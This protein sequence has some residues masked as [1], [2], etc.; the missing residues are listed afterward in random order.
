M[1]DVN[2]R[3]PNWSTNEASNSP[4]GTTTIGTGLDDNLRQIQATIRADLASKGNDIASAGTTD[5]G[6]VAGSFHDITGTTTITGLGSVSAGIHKWLQFD[7]TV[8][9]KYN[10]SSLILP[11][12]AD[13]TAQPGD[14]LYAVSLG[15]GNWIVPAYVPR[16]G[17]GVVAPDLSAFTAE[18]SPATDDT[19]PFSDTSA[20][21]AN[22]KITVS[23][24]L[25]VINSLTE[26]TSPDT[27]ADFLLTYDTSTSSVKKAKPS[28]IAAIAATQAQMETSSL[29]AT[30]YV[31]PARQHLHPGHPK[32][33]VAFDPGATITGSFNVA[34]VTKHGTGDYTVTINQTLSSAAFGATVTAERTAG[35][36]ILGQVAAGGKTTTTCRVQ[37]FGINSAALVDPTSC[38]VTIY[39]DL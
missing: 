23:N 39:G 12:S 9:L 38:T 32:A 4:A 19:I 29:S 35:N 14:T 37:T 7:S 1:A 3:L 6:A 2:S 20:S 17:R 13:I 28:N 31:S 5:L 27:S 25:K 26:D 11:S 15:S 24:L 30:V 33:W 16:S 18:T 21:S 10:A 36:H 8:T 34:S 22:R